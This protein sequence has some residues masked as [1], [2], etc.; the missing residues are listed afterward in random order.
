MSG[1]R[2]SPITAFSERCLRA[3][4]RRWP[5]QLRDELY[6]EWSAELHAIGSTSDGLG[7]LRY[8]YH[9]L[10]FAASLVCSAGVTDGYE[11]RTRWDQFLIAIPALRQSLLLLTVPWLSVVGTEVLGDQTKQLTK[12]LHLAIGTA[13]GDQLL[14]QAMSGTCLVAALVAT[15]FAGVALSRTVSVQLPAA[16]NILLLAAGTAA[17]PILMEIDGTSLGEFAVGA[18]T[19]PTLTVLFIRRLVR[20]RLRLWSRLAVAMLFGLVAT[21]ASVTLAAIPQMFT[22]G[23][24]AASWQ[25]AISLF[26][27]R[28]LF[29]VG[30]PSTAVQLL[31]FAIPL[32]VAFGI[33]YALASSTSS[34][35]EVA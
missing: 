13:P 23:R 12:W 15:A 2:F 16:V 21:Y 4:V 24:P 26:D 35:K 8:A 6:A 29:V 5:S 3:A 1:S 10:R 11:P 18:L 34:S 28:D 31:S 17:L 25:P 9:R 19:W 30:V 33:A 22:T 14:G 20:S 7:Q 32:C 27:H